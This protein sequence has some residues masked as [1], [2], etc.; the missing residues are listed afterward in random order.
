MTLEY[1]FAIT[2]NAQISSYPPYEFPHDFRH[3][4]FICYLRD[5]ALR[6][7]YYDFKKGLYDIETLGMMIDEGQLDKFGKLS[8]KGM[9]KGRKQIFVYI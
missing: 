4:G 3:R 9:Q 2:Y 5:F 7:I 6:Q 1:E 8:V